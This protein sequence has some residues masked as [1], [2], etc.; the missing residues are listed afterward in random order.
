MS[1]NVVVGTGTGGLHPGKPITRQ[2]GTQTS[3]GV[4]EG[5]PSAAPAETT[6]AKAVGGRQQIQESVHVAETKTI[7]RQITAQDIGAHLL[8]M[9]FQDTEFNVNFSSLLLRFGIELSKDNLAKALNMLEGTNKSMTM[10]ESVLVLMSKGITEN[11]QA[12][13]ILGDYLASNPQLASQIL[14]LK[15]SC[16]NLLSAMSSS[17]ALLDPNLIGL[18]NGLLSQFENSLTDMEREYSFNSKNPSVDRMEFM[19]EIAALRALLKA[20]SDKIK[21]KEG[22]SPQELANLSGSINSTLGKLN[23]VFDNLVAQ[24]ILSQ[25]TQKGD[26]SQ[27][28]YLYY[29]IPNSFGNPPKNFEIMIGKDGGGKVSSINAK[30]TEIIMSME[31]ESLGKVSIK[32]EVRDKKVNFTFNTSD[33]ETRSLIARESSNLKSK[34]TSINYET[35]GLLVRVNPAM[36]N[37]KQYLINFLES[38][39]LLRIDTKI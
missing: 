15:G 26:I 38:D 29:Q 8:S 3:G 20:L 4:R 31:T 22:A 32:M 12:V 10:Q 14:S 7:T 17:K 39:H 34:M 6:G 21:S 23:G 28:N 27:T 25:N 9:G 35:T 19:M 24:T 30:N 1:E 18:L 33:E 11:P 37:L 36:T 13:R 5:F 2:T 16:S